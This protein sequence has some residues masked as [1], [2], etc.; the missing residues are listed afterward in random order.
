MKKTLSLV[1]LLWCSYQA[2]AQSMHVAT[3][4]IRQRNQVDTGNLWIDRKDKVCNLIKY[5]EFDIFGVQEAF[6]DQMDD[7]QKLLPKY[8]YVGVGR[9]DGK[10]KRSEEHTSELQSR[11]NL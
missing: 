7:M 4:N 5:H 11:E 8:A 2:F 10:E 6:K 9:D 3:Y 1:L